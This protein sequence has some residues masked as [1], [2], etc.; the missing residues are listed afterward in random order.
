MVR[1]LWMDQRL[2]TITIHA[3][4]GRAKARQHPAERKEVRNM[5]TAQY[6]A[7]IQ[8]TI[9]AEGWK[10]ADKANKLALEMKQITTEQ[11]SKAANLIAKAFLAN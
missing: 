5:N 3:P 8:E 7:F 6:I 11:Y 2:I 9:N 4:A 10:V 1:P